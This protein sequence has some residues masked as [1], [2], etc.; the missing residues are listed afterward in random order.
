MGEGRSGTPDGDQDAVEAGGV[1]GSL[2][3][4]DRKC[5]PTLIQS[6]RIA[7]ASVLTGISGSFGDGLGRGSSPRL[8]SASIIL[9][10]LDA[11]IGIMDL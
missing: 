3:I 2:G 1:G 10:T 8:R 9:L 5:S 7:S 6:P 4:T 11:K